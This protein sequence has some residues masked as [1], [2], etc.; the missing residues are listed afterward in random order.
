METYPDDAAA[1]DAH[2]ARGWGTAGQITLQR[3]GTPSEAIVAR[4][5]ELNDTAMASV[6][7]EHLSPLCSSVLQDLLR[8]KRFRALRSQHAASDSPLRMCAAHAD[9]TD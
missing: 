7:D 6:E 4:V 8:F 1:P 9:V 5:P 3:R 2:G